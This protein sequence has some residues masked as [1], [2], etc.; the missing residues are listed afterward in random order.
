MIRCLIIL[1]G[2]ISPQLQ[3]REDFNY[4]PSGEPTPKGIHA[5]IFV[6]EHAFA[7]EYMKFVQ[8]T[9]YGYNIWVDDLSN[10]NEHDTLELGRYYFPSEIIIT[11]E[12]KYLDYAVDS[13]SKFKRR[14][15][16]S[17]RFVKG[18]V[19]HELTHIWF[20]QIMLEMQSYN[21]FSSVEYNNFRIYHPRDRGY[22]AEFIEEGICE[23][24]ANKAGEIINPEK[25][26]PDL[27]GNWDKY[28][29]K[30]QYAEYYVRQ[31]LDRYD[32]IKEGIKMILLTPP[33]TKEEIRNPELYYKRVL[34]LEG[35]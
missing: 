21:Q 14:T 10:Y 29:I 26:V 18:C 35:S 25:V 19:F 17:N 24:I 11:N 33:P 4:L 16:I 3:S 28:E 7:Q 20:Q 8:D 34:Y 31:I 9:L 12:R 22:G 5:Y 2:L 27:E 13:L 23:Y 1:F 15:T 6:N 32:N 30:Y